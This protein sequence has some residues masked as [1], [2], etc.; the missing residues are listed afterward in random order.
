MIPPEVTSYPQQNTPFNQWRYRDLWMNPTPIGGRPAHR[1]C[2]HK[3]F[4]FNGQL[5]NRYLDRIAA[6][7]GLWHRPGI[8]SPPPPLRRARRHRPKEAHYLRHA[9]LETCR[10][11]FLRHVS[12]FLVIDMFK[13]SVTSNE[14][15]SVDFLNRISRRIELLHKL[16]FLDLGAFLLLKIFWNQKYSVWRAA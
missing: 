2:F 10:A 7:C 4:R 9:S 1:R 16:T 5:A 12:P 15:N 8:T 3:R 11:S 6:W 13:W 14:E